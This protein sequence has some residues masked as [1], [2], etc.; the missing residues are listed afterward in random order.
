LTN[1]FKNNDTYAEWNNDTTSP[2]KT[3]AH[4]IHVPPE[5][6]PG[7]P[8]P[9]TGLAQV[10]T[11]GLAK[12][13]VWLAPQGENWPEDDPYFSKAPWREATILP[14]PDDWGGGLPEGKLPPGVSR[15]DA[16]T[17]KP[18]AWPL[19]NTIAHWA[20]LLE[21]IAP[22]KYELRCRTI[23]ARG[24]AQPMPRPFAKGGRNAIQVAKLVVG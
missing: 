18:R 24:F 2:L 15:I 3:C 8:L 16:A 23:D 1:D 19:R 22:G 12:V 6:R 14:P 10:G 4:F 21:G 7:R 20:V 9:V 13:E 11:S 5:A 17:G